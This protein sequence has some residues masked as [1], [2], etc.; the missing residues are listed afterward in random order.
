MKDLQM[1]QCEHCGQ[2]EV[3]K[4]KHMEHKLSHHSE[5]LYKCKHCEEKFPTREIL[6]EHVANHGEIKRAFMCD[7]CGSDFRNKHALNTHCRR[8]TG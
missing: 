4:T 7:I 8:H 6:K 5:N 1:Y 2:I 3:I